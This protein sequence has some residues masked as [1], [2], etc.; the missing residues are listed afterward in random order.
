MRNSP[1]PPPSGRPLAFPQ[2]GIQRNSH[3]E[4]NAERKTG[5]KTNQ[6]TNQKTEPKKAQCRAFPFHSHFFTNRNFFSW[7]ITSQS[8]NS[9]SGSAANAFKVSVRSLLPNRSHWRRA[10]SNARKLWSTDSLQL[11]FKLPSKRPPLVSEW[12]FRIAEYELYKRSPA[13]RIPE[14]IRDAY[15]DC[16]SQLNSLAAGNLETGA[17]LKGKSSNLPP[18][19]ILIP[20]RESLFDSRSMRGF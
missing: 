17:V 14:K 3:G 18:P 1:P 15:E 12:A 8:K 20:E 4:K 6:K 9:N 19:S 10:S 5:K 7:E 16:I 13:S 11:D 2:L